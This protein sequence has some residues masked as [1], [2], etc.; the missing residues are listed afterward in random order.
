MLPDWL[1]GWPVWAVLTLVCGLPAFRTVTELVKWIGTFGA[2][3]ED[4]RA[5][6]KVDAE[7]RFEAARDSL[8]SRLEAELRKAQGTM[9]GYEAELAKLR[10]ARALFS[11][12]MVELRSAALAAR[13]MVHEME[14]R[15][16]EP[17]TVFRPL[18][19]IDEDVP[20]RN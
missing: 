19:S 8:M 1:R 20:M 7:Q 5:R 11:D 13:A 12:A 18:P 3:R 2:G 14:N 9:D 6:A 4:A 10:R 15:M 17:A 16:G